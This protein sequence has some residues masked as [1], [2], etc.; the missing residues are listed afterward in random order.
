MYIEY[1]ESSKCR[2]GI[3]TRGLKALILFGEVHELE[4][5]LLLEEV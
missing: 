5:G 3:F 2:I 4:I 1:Y